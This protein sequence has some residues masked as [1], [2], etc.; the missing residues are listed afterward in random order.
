MGR[1]KRALVDAARMAVRLAQEGGMERGGKVLN[2]EG[3]N[4]IAQ[5]GGGQ[6]DGAAELLPHRRRQRL[7]LAHL[8]RNSHRVH[9]LGSGL[10]H[11]TAE[12]A[13]RLEEL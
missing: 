11:V 12:F 5:E 4:G 13:C 6:D 9:D 8:R 3:G 7:P 2:L 1:H 10:E